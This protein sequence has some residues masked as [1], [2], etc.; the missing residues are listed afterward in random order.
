MQPRALWKR[1]ARRGKPSPPPPRSEGPPATARSFDDVRREKLARLQPFLRQDMSCRIVNGKLDF[2][3]EELRA[4]T[5]IVDTE[6][7]SSNGYDDAMLA[8]VDRYRD[9]LVLDCGA[10]KRQ[11]YFPNV[12]NYEIVDY[13]STDVLG[14]GEKLPFLDNTFDALISIAVLE[15]VRDPFRCAREI[16]RVLKPGGEL[17]C[18]VPFL[19]PLHGYPHHYFNAT[20]QGI[21][22]LFEDYLQVREV[23]VLPS[24]HPIWS[25]T[26]ILNL[27]CAALPEDHRASLKEM[28]VADLLDPPPTYLERPFCSALPKSVQLELASATVLTAIKL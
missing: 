13:D 2:L 6:N 21:R 1:L 14:V 7:V 22:A 25:L 26:W 17:Y 15:H 8:L 23:D 16:A 18:A 4:E 28:R 19:Q 5:R 9:G 20:P 24:T 11:T 3:T 10:G 27:W 12:V